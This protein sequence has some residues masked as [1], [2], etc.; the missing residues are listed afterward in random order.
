MY[1]LMIISPYTQFEWNNIW[2]NVRPKTT[3]LLEA[4]IVYFSVESG[5]TY[6]KQVLQNVRKYVST[7]CHMNQMPQKGSA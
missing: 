3:L 7:W 5:R 4:Q 2:I 6:V 1:I